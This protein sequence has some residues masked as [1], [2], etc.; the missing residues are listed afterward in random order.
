MV[1]DVEGLKAVSRT[2]A[3]DA[4]R[5]PELDGLRG[6]A[7]L[8]V[9]LCHYV[10]SAQHAELGPW[11][12]RVLSAFGAGW[13]GVDLF[14]VLSGFLIGRILLDAR[15]APSYFQ[16]FYM[17]RVHRILPVYYSWILFYA[18]VVAAGIWL[19]PWG[20]SLPT[21]A[22]RQIPIELLFLQNM[23]LG[24]PHFQWVWFAVTWSLAVE[25]Q[26]Y[27]IAPPLI[28][29]L[30]PH[31]LVIVLVNTIVLAP[32]LRIIV[33]R[34]WLPHTFAADFLMPC[35]ADALGW[36][37]LLALAWRNERFRSYLAKH[38]VVVQRT[39]GG[40][41]L[42][43][44]ILV[45]WLARPRSI[46]TETI[47]YTWLAAF[48]AC[49]LVTALSQN[50]TWVARVLRWR[51]L[52]RLGVVSY[53]VYIIHLAANHFMHE[54]VLHAAPQ[55]Y[56]LNGVA[57]TLLALGLTL[58]VASISWVYFEKPVIRRG[59][60]YKYWSEG[61]PEAAELLARAESE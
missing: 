60:R 23:Q 24:M 7:I 8:L 53:C 45:W 18:V 52:R 32:I 25:E 3:P 47:G 54:V 13:S 51:P 50:E 38:P 26:F 27:L 34:Y 10:G 20:F 46:V 42:G 57:V 21:S 55:I 44:A 41:F 11:P 30:S 12:H 22:L 48:Y 36:G 58:G 49:L 15:T 31:K 39:L 59:H 33:F 29:F 5:I 9:I 43:C 2:G 56:N 35:R 28:R 4:N 40:L 61:K 37:I 14:F 16:A 6:L 1:T 19:A 17:R